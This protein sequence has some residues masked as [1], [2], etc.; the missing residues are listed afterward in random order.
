M[1]RIL[2]LLL[3]AI[4]IF[5]LCSCGGSGTKQSNDPEVNFE[6][7][8]DGY[9]QYYSHFIVK[10]IN[11]QEIYDEFRPQVNADMSEEELYAVMVDML[12]RLRDGHVF[13]ASPYGTYYYEGWWKPPSHRINFNF[14]LIK[15]KYIPAFQTAQNE[16]FIYGVIEDRIGYLYIKSFHGN[17][18]SW[19]Q[20]FDNILEQFKDLQ[21]MIF[22]VRG[23]MGGYSPLGDAIAGRFADRKRVSVYIRYRNIGTDHN[24]FTDP[25]PISIKPR[26]SW[27]FF[28]PVVVLT[29][30]QCYS[31][32]ENFVL[33]MRIFPQV[34]V[35]GD[36]TGGGS[37]SSLQRKLPNG[38]TYQIPRMMHYT[39]EMEVFEDIGLKPDFRID[40]D[41]L[42]EASGKDTIVE[43]A[44]LHITEL[45]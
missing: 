31:A 44:I 21:G 12:S 6:A 24:S 9:N 18:D 20:D 35:I 17:K 36:Y 3:M 8:W 11:W 26:G 10:D 2:I 19:I 39:P 25:T 43:Q 4:L 13:L 40:L 37:G 14:E 41:P 29:N 32:C 42:D 30:R 22:D 45:S 33:D 34:T 16:N 5:T 15:S 27:Q 28:K 38:W 23:N 1:K 7:L